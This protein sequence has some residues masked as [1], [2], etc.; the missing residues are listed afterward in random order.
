MAIHIYTPTMRV[1]VFPGTWYSS[2]L[3]SCQPDEPKVVPYFYLRSPMTGEFEQL[4][5]HLLVMVVPSFVACLFI[6]FLYFFL[7]GF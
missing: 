4:F 7:L 5:V 1:L 3:M 6:S 2:F